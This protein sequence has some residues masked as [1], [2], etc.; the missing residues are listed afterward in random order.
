MFQKVRQ[1]LTKYGLG[2]GVLAGALVVA[3]ACSRL[4]SAA[5]LQVN[6]SISLITIVMR[7]KKVHERQGKYPL[8]Y[9]AKDYHGRPV[10]YV[11]N[12]TSYLL[13]S[14]GADRIADRQYELSEVSGIEAADNCFDADEDSVVVTGEARVRCLK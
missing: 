1:L 2:L 3:A 5:T 4:Y 8:R 14:Y 12:G 7:L 13:V 10:L 11:S 6:N 9:D